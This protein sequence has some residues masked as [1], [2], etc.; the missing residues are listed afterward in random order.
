MRYI[1]SI[2]TT[3]IICYKLIVYLATSVHTGIG[4]KIYIMH[5]I[6]ALHRSKYELNYVCGLYGGK[7]L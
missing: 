2:I 1:Y 5:Y 4:Y 3:L 6:Y 7:M